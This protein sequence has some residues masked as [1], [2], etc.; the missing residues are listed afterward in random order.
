MMN[1]FVGSSDV[2]VGDEMNP[3]ASTITD[4]ARDVLRRHATTPMSS[5]ELRAGLRPLVRRARDDGATIEQLLVVFKRTWAELPESRSPQS[6][7][8][9]GTRRLER[10]VTL[11]IDTYYEA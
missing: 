10:V 3:A 4:G 11:L 9:D 1:G 6:L 5:A 7:R 2:A 8:S